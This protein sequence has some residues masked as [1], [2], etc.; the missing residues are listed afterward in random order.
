MVTSSNALVNDNHRHV[1]KS[2]VQNDGSIAVSGDDTVDA[3]KGTGGLLLPSSY[4]GTGTSRKAVASCLECI[5]RYTLY[6]DQSSSVLCAH[7]V[8]TCPVGKI[9]YRVWFAAEKESEKVVGS[10]CWGIAKPATRRDLEAQVKNSALRYVP[11]LKPAVAPRGST[12]TSVPIMVWSG[13]PAVFKPR[14]MH[15][16]GHLVQITATAMWQWLW[17]DGSSLWSANPGARYPKPT[18]SHLFRRFGNYQ[19]RVR[20]V[21][22]AVYEVPGIGSFSAQG[23][24]ISQNAHFQ[25]NVRTGRSVLVSQ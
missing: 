21:W 3:Y 14:P 17:G 7:A 1:L 24:L 15:L 20:T 19:V 9:R 10:V 23:D 18:I 22:R 2:L 4:S 8:S 16:G 11:A 25:M 12:Y 5:W 6:C 13:Q